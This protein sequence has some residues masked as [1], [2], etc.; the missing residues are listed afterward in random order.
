MFMVYALALVV[1]LI[2]L[3]VLGIAAFIRPLRRP[4]LHLALASLL[5]LLGSFCLW[6]VVLLAF[7]PLELK[8]WIFGSL[9][10][11]G[12]GLGALVGALLGH[13]LAERLAPLDLRGRL[14]GAFAKTAPS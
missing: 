10:L 11:A 5:G 6:F 7:G 3:P 13:F 9:S 14:R 8:D 1:W 12:M 2:G 4:A